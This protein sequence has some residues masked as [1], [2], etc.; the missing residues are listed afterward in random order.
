MSPGDGKKDHLL[1]WGPNIKT[2]YKK[3]EKETVIETYGD[4]FD[5]ML[6]VYNCLNCGKIYDCR[7]GSSSLTGDA[8]QFMASG[9]TCTFCNKKYNVIERDV[10]LPNAKKLADEKASEELRNKLVKYD[11]ESSSRTV[12]IDDQNDYYITV[13]SNAWLSKEEREQL[14]SQIKEEEEAA[15]CSSANSRKVTIDL[16]GRRVL[17]EDDA[18]KGRGNDED[19]VLLEVAKSA[20]MAEKPRGG[21]ASVVGQNAAAFPPR[22][23]NEAHDSLHERNRHFTPSTYLFVESERNSGL[24][25]RSGKRRAASTGYRAR[26]TGGIVDYDEDLSQLGFV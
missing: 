25:S 26:N 1:E 11:R 21:G 10:S 18:G 16:L 2:K 12:V 7:A 4:V 5:T 13:D 8:K 14:R 6:G 17:I 15:R 22:G 9:G 24:S 23:G 19:A 20:S 3:K